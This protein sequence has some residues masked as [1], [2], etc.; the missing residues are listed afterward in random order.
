[1]EKKA[2]KGVPSFESEANILDEVTL[3]KKAIE[4]LLETNP[5]MQK[6]AT[7][8]TDIIRFCENAYKMNVVLLQKVDE[9][10]AMILNNAGKINTM[11]KIIKTDNENIHEL[12]E[13]YENNL[14][15]LKK[16]QETIQRSKNLYQ[17]LR[18]TVSDLHEKVQRG[19]A[20]AYGDDQSLTELSNEVKNL[21]KEKAKAISDSESLSQQIKETKTSLDNLNEQISKLNE[22]N[23]SLLSVDATYD[24]QLSSLEEIVTN[25]S[26]EIMKLKPL[27]VEQKSTIEDQKKQKVRS[28]NTN[29]QLRNDKYEVLSKLGM[30]RDSTKALKEKNT[31]RTKF[32]VELKSKST[33]KAGEIEDSAIKISLSGKT[34]DQLNKDMDLITKQTNETQEKYEEE[35]ELSKNIAAQKIELRKRVRDLRSDYIKQAYAVSQSENEVIQTQRKNA[36]T[37]NQ[38][39]NEKRKIE[40]QKK[41]T[42]DVIDQGKNTRSETTTLKGDLQKVKEKILNLFDEV[43]EQRTLAIQFD[44]KANI[45]ADLLKQINQQNAS[46]QKELEEYQ[47]KQEHQEQLSEKLRKERNILKKKCVSISQENQ[48]LLEEIEQLQNL[49][50]MMKT[51]SNNLTEK[52]ID[53]HQ[54]SVS[55]STENTF[56]EKENVHYKENTQGVERIISRLQTQRQTLDFILTATQHDYLQQQKEQNACLSSIELIEKDIQKRKTDDEQLRSNILTIERNIDKAK[57]VY[58]D[59]VKSIY[60]K[61]MELETLQ[62]KTKT[63]EEKRD[64]TKR[65][66]FL[67]FRIQSDLLLERQKYSALIYEFSVPRNIH[68]WDVIEAT[69]PTYASQLRYRAAISGKLDVAH[70]LLICLNE[71]KEKLQAEVNEMKSK[72]EKSLSKAEVQKRIE[73]YEKDIH[74]K[75]EAMRN[76]R[77]TIGGNQDVM[78]RSISNIDTLREK[79]TVKRGTTANIRSRTNL[80]SMKLRELDNNSNTGLFITESAAPIPL[81]AGFIP[82]EAPQER[83][84]SFQSELHVAPS[85]P[86]TFR[87]KRSPLLSANK[88]IAKPLTPHTTF[89]KPIQ[90]NKL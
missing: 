55:T 52:I 75:E 44:A 39:R 72:A 3:V 11:I 80:T 46:H 13:E 33:I 6:Y 1:M 37:E 67:Y 78:N 90:L 89:M 49:S 48:E 14:Q 28:S 84:V 51:E 36:S 59:K 29:S 15:L 54:G 88:K 53:D 24:K 57:H 5:E 9:Y 16:T 69:D 65:A 2:A 32:L 41:T 64:R 22:Q 43:D 83:Q 56:L 27:I 7:S 62:Q 34:I 26:D 19:E 61:R 86:H 4:E 68:R 31:T 74:E 50:S 77:V 17:D 23:E 38:I 79:I 35:M 20:F 87:N 70:K 60:E 30:L 42:K 76:M 66:R 85:E 25:T 21:R 40:E 73:L 81:G 63:L 45:Q 82:K 58:E 10:N 47:S 18:R 71:E 8:A 12:K